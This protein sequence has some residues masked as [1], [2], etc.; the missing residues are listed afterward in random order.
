VRCATTS[1]H[2]SINATL[3]ASPPFYPQTGNRVPQ[4]DLLRPCSG[5][6]SLG[7]VGKEV[8]EAELRDSAI[9]RRARVASQE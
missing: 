7:A 2:R 4:I 9:A 6:G 1:V 8:V 5:G 3:V